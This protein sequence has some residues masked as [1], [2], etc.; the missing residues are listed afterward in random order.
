MDDISLVIFFCPNENCKDYGIRNQGNIGKR[1][2]YGKDNRLLL[3][4]RTCKKRFSETRCTAFFGTKYPR[5]TI[6]NIIRTVAEGNGVRATARILGLSKDGV[7]HIILVAGEHCEKVLSNL[8]TSLTL[9]EVQLD[10]LWTFMKKNKARPR[11]ISRMR[12][13]EVGSGR[14]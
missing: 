10:E 14:P 13:V 12:T 8:L 4:C 6:Q 5:K 11:K 1:A 7:N 9:T 2:V 3:Y